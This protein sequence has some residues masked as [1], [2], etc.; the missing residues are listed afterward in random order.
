M[1]HVDDLSRSIAAFDH[2][3]TLV[4]V[5][6]MS[7]SSWLVAGMIP[8]VDRQPVKKLEPDPDALQR[9]LERWRAEATKAGR[10][11]QRITLGYEAG[12]DGFWCAPRRRVSS[13]EEGSIQTVVD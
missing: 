12:R 11:I 2:D 1:I 10:K 5:I 6:E 4:V 13:M 8:G 3:S 9:L 7:K